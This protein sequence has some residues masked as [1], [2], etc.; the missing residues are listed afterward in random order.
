M[1]Q[2]I[3]IDKT[4]P[5]T[6][7]LDFSYLLDA[8][9]GKHGFTKVKNGRL[10]FE[11]GTRAKFIGFNMP[12]RSNTPDHQTAERLAD[13]FASLGINVIRLHAAD[14]PLGP[15]GWSSSLDN[16]L[17]DYNSGSSRHFHEEGLDRFDYFVAKLK[18]KGIYVQVDLLVARAFQDGDDLEYPNAPGFPFKSFTHINE[19]LIQLQKEYATKL[20][21]H[22]NPY[23]GL[24]LID[25]PAVMTIQIANEDSAI[26]GTADI[27]N[28]KGI[29]PYRQELQRRFNRY[30]LA[31]YD[32]RKNLAEAWTFN[33]ICALGEDEDPEAGTVWFPEG[34]FYQVPNHP[35]GEWNGNVSPARYADFIEFGID[36]NKRYYG[37]MIDHVR[38]LG[39]KVPINTS[40]LLNG[41]ADV[42]SHADGDI[43]E[44][45]TYF[46]HPM[47]PFHQETLVVPGMREYVTS[48]PLKVHE[49]GIYMRTEMLQMATTAALR[50]KPFILSEW[51][52]Y[53]V[54]PFHSTAF[55]SMA[56]YACLND[57]D[58]LMLYCFHTSESWNDQPD[59]VIEDIFDAYNDPSLICQFGFMASIFLKGLV[60]QAE[61]KVDLVF[62]KNDLLTLP[63]SF[64]MPNTF[65]PYITNMRNVFL[66]Q[67]DIYTGVADVAVTAGFLNNGDLSQ[68]E[69]AVYFAWSPYRDAM[70]HAS[71]GGRLERLANE[72]DELLPGAKLGDQ[73]L[74]FEDIAS[75]AGNGNYTTFAA[76]LDAAFKR[77]GLLHHDR[78]L[79]GNALVS[80]TGELEADPEAGTFR[81]RAEGCSYFSGNPVGGVT[82]TNEMSLSLSNQRISAAALPLNGTSL[83][84]A[85]TILLTIIGET[86][87][88]ETIFTV[89][90]FV[91]TVNHQGKL[92]ADTPEGTLFV[93]CNSATLTVLDTVGVPITQIE[94]TPFEDGMNFTLDGNIP[95]VHFLLE[96]K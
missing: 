4:A 8:P 95:A 45:N 60:R 16:P 32:T 20:L 12:T 64:S 18:E 51:N 23:T 7:A 48:N 76:N 81:I 94:G 30:L 42:Y 1:K 84:R 57:W 77:W 54:N 82:L 11:D 72:T 80:D 40:N 25:D 13:R 31:K 33:G 49:D 27:K 67:G 53:G 41:A 87:M 28:E 43:M 3:K 35:M 10:Y 70:R 47:P 15:S 2:R 46:N 66:E 44:N 78:G 34:D 69:R 63:P 88:D 96:R 36:I 21:T 55:L 24:A 6:G 90:G 68:A 9:A 39:A 38:S 61:N 74:V 37:T 79:V 71:D 85:E 86:G 62:T 92:Y 14:A 73:T 89:E 5:N 26:K 59:D 58:G 17:I 91:T 22:V 83:E 75:L 65:L 50:D 29:E 56:A 52:E 93:R 19:R